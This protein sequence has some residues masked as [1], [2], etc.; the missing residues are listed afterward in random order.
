MFARCL[1]GLA[2]VAGIVSASPSSY[3]DYLTTYTLDDVALD[4]GSITGSFIYDSTTHTMF[5]DALTIVGPQDPNI[6]GTSGASIALSNV[7][8]YQFQ[9]FFVLARTVVTLAVLFDQGF[10]PPTTGLIPLSA[11]SVAQSVEDY[12]VYQPTGY[13]IADTVNA[14]EPSSLALLGSGLAVI[15]ALAGIRFGRRTNK[16]HFP[17]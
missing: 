1:L 3:A 16:L 6:F 2:T 15:L 7:D 11:K 17:G 9:F 12:I 5:K 14:A 8:A 13:L 10:F 4:G